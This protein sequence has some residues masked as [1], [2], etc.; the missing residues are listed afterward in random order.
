MLRAA[1]FFVLIMLAGIVLVPTGAIAEQCPAGNPS[2]NRAQIVPGSPCVLHDAAGNAWAFTKGAVGNATITLNGKPA[3]AGTAIV[4]SDGKAYV[5][6]QCHD[7][8][9]GVYAPDNIYSSFRQEVAPG[10]PLLPPPYTVRDHGMESRYF[11]MASAAIQLRAGD[12]LEIAP[13]PNSIPA[14]AGAGRINYRDVTIEGNHTKI[15][16]SVELGQ[17][18]IAAFTPQGHEPAGNLTVKDIDIGYN[19]AAPD[20]G[21]YTGIQIDR[22][23]SGF[24]LLNSTLH[25]TDMCLLTGGANGTVILKNDV[26]SHCGSATAGSGAGFNHNVYLSWNGTNSDTDTVMISGGRSVDVTHEG[27]PLKL[28]FASG[29]I[30]NFTI[31]CTGAFDDCEPNWP[32]DIPCGGNYQLSHMVIERG[33]KASNYGMV[34]Y[35][36]EQAIKENCPARGRTYSLTLEHVML[37]DDGPSDP[38]HVNFAV[39]AGRETGTSCDSSGYTLV[40]KDSIVISNPKAGPTGLGANVIDGGGNRYFASRAAAGLKPYPFLPGPP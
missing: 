4:I 11:N 28:R 13:Q 16:C 36:E 38:R 33:D 39:C 27:D 14:W 22:G 25:D 40:V 6:G 18:S 1:G 17:G 7:L 35:G 9:W 23:F 24:T 12:T 3:T 31:G 26:F 8:M 20:N 2:P 21:P 34:R 30:T 29:S 19:R 37:I 10:T 32:I 5:S 15:E